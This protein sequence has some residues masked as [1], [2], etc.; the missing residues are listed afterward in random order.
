MP[1]PTDVFTNELGLAVLARVT[2]MIE[3]IGPAT[4]RVSRTQISYR[5]RRGFVYLWDPGRWLR[6][7]DVNIVVSLALE[8]RIESPRWKEVVHQTTKLWMHHLEV[9]DVDELDDEFAGWL[10]EAYADAG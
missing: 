8:H 2:E 4:Q 7:S 9:T 1:Q 6:N 3:E 5:R 10:A